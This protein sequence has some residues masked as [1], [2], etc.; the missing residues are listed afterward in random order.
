MFGSSAG[1]LSSA[2]LT[3]VA[4]RSSGRK[5]LSEPLLARPMGERA[6][7][8]MTAS[9]MAAT[10]LVR[11]VSVA[12]GTICLMS[13]RAPGLRS[14]WAELPTAGRWLL[15]TVAIQT[16]GRGLTLPFTIIYLHEVR[17]FELGLSG[18]LMA[19]IAVVALLVTMPG[20]TLTDR[21]GARVMILIGT[22]V[23]D[24]RQRR[25]G[26]RHPPRRRR[27]RVRPDRRQ[28]R[29][30]LAGVQRPDRLGRRRRAAAALLRRQLRPGQPRHRARRGRSAASSST[31][32][33]AG[34]VHRDL[35]GRRR[36]DAGADRAA[37]RPAAPRPRAGR[38]ARGGTST[39]AGHLP[40]DPAPALGALADPADVPRDVRRLR[41]AR[42]R[43]SRRSPAR[44]PRCRRARSASPSRST[45]R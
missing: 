8:T 30:R 33:P 36:L 4:V 39:S 5:S 11:P 23:D 14:F 13:T 12:W 32:Q 29:H 26:L 34:D 22:L 3:I 45:P 37:A 7:E 16:L 44:S 27:P 25:A 40:R 10:L 38:A 35:P 41:P 18:T 28:L 2:V 42:G 15:S 21:Y 43:A 20:G 24:G 9:G 6:A 17:G 31:C 1:I 19:L